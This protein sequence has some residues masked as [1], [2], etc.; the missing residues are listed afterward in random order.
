ME[1]LQREKD[2]IEQHVARAEEAEESQGQ[3]EGVPDREF[4]DVL[5]LVRVGARV[6]RLGCYHVGDVF[7]GR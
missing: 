2:E 7:Q 5:G 6:G 3:R 4:P 1:R